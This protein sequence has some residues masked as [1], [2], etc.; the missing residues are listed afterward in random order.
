M[1]SDAGYTVVPFPKIRIGA[2]DLLRKGHQMHTIHGLIEV[3]VTKPR[4]YVREHKA[5]TGETLS[6]T[7]FIATCLA[8]AVDENKIMQAYRDWRNRLILFDEVD[9]NTMVEREADGA[10]MGTPYIIR[11][12]NKKTFREIHQEI[13]AA[14]WTAVEKA[15]FKAMRWYLLLP[16]FIRGFLWWILDKSPHLWK[17]V[18]GTVGITAVGMFGK[19]VGWGIPISCNTL[20]LTLGGIAEK[21]GVVDGRIE[22]REY[23]CMTLSFDHDIVDGAPAARFTA[24][25]KELIECGF[26]LCN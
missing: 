7:A 22:I 26:G 15:E 10:K 6:F 18:G 13:R 8:Q 9:V 2:I 20:S 12:A 5:K 11:A 14:Q 24:R 16:S 19:S 1:K 21:P 23:L 17:R 25:L 4:L 3:D